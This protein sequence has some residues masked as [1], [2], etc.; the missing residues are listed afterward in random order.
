MTEL[1]DNFKKI[2]AH[3]H[4][5]TVRDALFRYGSE[6]SFRFLSINTDMP[7]FPSLEE[8]EK[9]SLQLLERHGKQLN[10][11]TSFSCDKWNSIDWQKGV[12]EKIAQSIDNGAIGV[13]VWKNIGMSLKDDTGK[14]VTIDHPSF[15]PIFRFLEENDIVLLGHIGEPKNCWLPLD[16]MTVNSDH[17]YFSAHPEYHM[18][19]HPECLG[20]EAHL[21]A[22]D[23]MLLK[24]PKLRYV[25]L[26]LASEE[27]NT[28][29]VAH[30]LNRFPTAM[31]DLAERICHLQHQA[32]TDW[33]KIYDFLVKYQDRIIYGTDCVDDNNLTDEELVR[34][35]NNRYR[36]HWKFFTENKL[37]S[38][39]KVKGQ[40]KG[41]GLPF[42]VVEKIYRT[43]AVKTYRI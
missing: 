6:H 32:V 2:D 37:M 7:F 17:D 24:H 1:Y 20:Y 16:E 29:N 25:A 30:F 21:K 10:F 28:D 14:Y 35:M 42:E 39:A 26:H 31:V 22:R 41:L 11:V 40:F 36:L 27:W 23:A 34:R 12:I 18:Y 13:K 19:R 38:A 5:N 4:F 15:A 33:Q 8:Q 43:N 3:V 9:T